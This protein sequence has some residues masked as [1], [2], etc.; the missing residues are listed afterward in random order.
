MTT[1]TIFHEVKDA[2]KWANAW[3][4]GPGSRHEMFAE[5]GIKAKTFRDPKNPNMSGVVAEI[6][7]MKK[8]DELMNSEMGRKAMAE[9]GI[10]PETVRILAEFQP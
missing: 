3:K 1:V 6:P 4:K 9:D 8:F 5:F 10:K 7:D 2:N